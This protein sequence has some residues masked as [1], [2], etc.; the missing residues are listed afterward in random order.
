MIKPC[1]AAVLTT[2]RQ[3]YGILRSTLLLLANDP[4]FDLQLLVGGMHFPARYGRTIEQIQK[5]GFYSAAQ[6]DWLGEVLPEPNA[7]IQIGTVA[8]L[9][10]DTLGRLKPDFLMVVGDRYE[11]AAAALAAVIARVPIVHLH[12]GEET[13]G[14]IDNQF[15]HAITK[16]SH[17]HLVSHPLHA[18]RVIQMG[19][20]PETVHVVGAPGLDNLFRSDLPDKATLEKT[21]GINLSPPVVIVT[22]HPVTINPIETNRA[23]SALVAAM[24]TIEATYIITLPNAD[25]GN[26]EI[27]STFR[28]WGI[29]HKRVCIL[30]SLGEQSYFGLM[31]LADTMI[32]NSSSG[33]I[34]AGSYQLPVVNIGCRQNGRLSGTNVIHAAPE[35]VSVQAALTRALSKEFRNSLIGTNSPY[36]DGK[37]GGRIINLL[38]T[39]QLPASTGKVFHT[40]QPLDNR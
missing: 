19:E 35:K 9:V 4:Q 5:D 25:P 12:G 1:K 36:G 17:L 18:S 3:D 16:M 7:Y 31:R 11:T 14:A 39:W 38:K 30:E 26:E 27:R 22:L 6:L 29:N 23:L 28:S 24:S 8:R 37:S 2:G 40:I 10:G 13:E 33:L 32:G 20:A 34:E 21:V 15:R